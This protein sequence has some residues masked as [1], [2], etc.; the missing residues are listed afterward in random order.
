[1]VKHHK[2]SPNDTR[3]YPE[4]AKKPAAKKPVQP[5][6]AYD[7]PRSEG[8]ESED[9]NEG[10]DSSDSASG[11]QD[12][13]SDTDGAVHDAHGSVEA[14]LI[15]IQGIPNITPFFL[16]ESTRR[17]YWGKPKASDPFIGP[18]R[19]SW[20]DKSDGQE[21]QQKKQPSGCTANLAE[22]GD[23]SDSVV[24][25]RGLCLDNAGHLT[26]D[27]VAHLVQALIDNE[28]QELWSMIPAWA[29]AAA[30]RQTD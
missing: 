5:A 15:A 29:K 2:F 24:I 18:Y 25:C 30:S 1:M 13:D 22:A 27:S 19:P 6:G 14:G 8:D 17:Q 21:V 28:P 9:S 20:T 11:Q 23:L 7:G 16:V 26:G 10:D 4:P 3:L 12:S